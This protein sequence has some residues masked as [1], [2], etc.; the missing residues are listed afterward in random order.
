M[1]MGV[2]MYVLVCCNQMAHRVLNLVLGAVSGVASLEVYVM[3][4]GLRSNSLFVTVIPP[5]LTSVSN[6]SCATVRC[7]VS[8]LVLKLCG[9]IVGIH[10]C[11]V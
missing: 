11:C 7:G 8:M 9:G 1:S 10:V 2:V 5:V 3:V 4:G 6:S